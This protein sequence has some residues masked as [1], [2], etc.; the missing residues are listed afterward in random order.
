MTDPSTRKQQQVNNTGRQLQAAFEG[1][2]QPGQAGGSEEYVWYA[3]W[4]VAT[5][6][7]GAPGRLHLT[8]SAIAGCIRSQDVFM[9]Y[10]CAAPILAVS[11]FRMNHQFFLPSSYRFWWYLSQAPFT[12]PSIFL[13]YP[14]PGFKILWWL[15]SEG[16]HHYSYPYCVIPKSN[17]VAPSLRCS[18]TPSLRHSVAPSLRH[19]VTPSLR[20]SVTFIK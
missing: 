7:E 20:H 14:W 5:L 12:V 18:V 17:F 1:S 19:S 16:W 2:R 4:Q 15:S 10:R 11:R 3:Y 9:R 8:R 6:G 13:Q